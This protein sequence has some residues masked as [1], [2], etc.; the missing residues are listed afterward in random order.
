MASHIL[1]I[2]K[3]QLSFLIYMV[4]FRSALITGMFPS[5]RLLQ[6]LQMRNL[7]LDY[8]L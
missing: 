3:T 5:K 4:S 1:Q 2:E 6:G 8:N 7:W